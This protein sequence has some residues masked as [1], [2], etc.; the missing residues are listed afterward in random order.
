MSSVESCLGICTFYQYLNGEQNDDHPPIP[1]PPNN[2]FKAQDPLAFLGFQ[3]GWCLDYGSQRKSWT[4]WAS[5][6]NNQNIT[7]A[8]PRGGVKNVIYN[9]GCVKMQVLENG[10]N[11]TYRSDVPPSHK[12]G[13]K[14]VSYI[15]D[16][17]VCLFGLPP[18]LSESPE[19]GQ[20]LFQGGGVKKN[21]I[22]T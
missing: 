4:S 18:L 2:S 14:N 11:W 15:F 10:E 12:T 13:V 5:Q 20:D 6:K 21:N 8:L 7:T 16:P 17:C 22:L 1:D 3:W 9:F 19:V